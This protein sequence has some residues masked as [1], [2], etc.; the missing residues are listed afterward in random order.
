M[1]H[2]HS[3]HGSW[4]GSRHDSDDRP[5]DDRPRSAVILSGGGAN[6]AYEVGVLKALMSGKSALTNYQPLRPDIL[7][8]TSVGAFNCAFLASQWDDYGAAAV[9][10]LERFWLEELAGSWQTNGVFRIRANPTPFFSPT[11]LLD[12][13]LTRAR[14]F[15]QDS[16]FLFLE[17]LQR[18]FDFVSSSQESLEQRLV[19]LLDLTSFISTEPLGRSLG[20]IDYEAI[21][22]SSCRLKVAATNWTTGELRV[23]WNHDMSPEFGPVALRASAAI[24]GLFPPVESGTQQYSDG[25]VLLNTPLSPAIHAGAEVLHVIYL[26]PAIDRIPLA[27]IPN[28]FDTLFR[29]QQ[30][31]WA[32]AYD[33]DIADAARI[34]KALEAVERLKS[35]DVLGAEY[36]TNLAAESFAAVRQRYRPLTIHRYRPSQAFEGGLGLLNFGRERLEGLIDRGFQD[37]LYHDCGEAGDIFPAGVEVPCNP[38]EWSRGPHDGPSP[39]PQAEETHHD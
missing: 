24:P 5:G 39:P 4:D 38:R 7:V 10:N 20:N 1:I 12:D 11:A 19:E 33:D 34:N 23:F 17:G 32:S 28:T 9:S 6:G 36:A 26:D 13:P 37:T 18:G 21:R 30:I 14:D 8:G 2:P 31:Q 22:R 35:Q 3:K 27:R 16:R 29:T 15:F 25:S